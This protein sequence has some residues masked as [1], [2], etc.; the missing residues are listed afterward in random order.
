MR[1]HLLRTE[2]WVV[3]MLNGGMIDLI[4]EIDSQGD[5][6]DWTVAIDRQIPRFGGIC[7]AVLLHT[8]RVCLRRQNVLQ[9]EEEVPAGHLLTS[10][11]HE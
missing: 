10:H 11:R 7:T 5:L 3:K 9:A 1:A 6:S 8:V 2:K 4:G